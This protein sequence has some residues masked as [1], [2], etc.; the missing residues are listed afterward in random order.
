MSSYRLRFSDRLNCEKDL[1]NLTG[2][3]VQESLKLD[4]KHPSALQDHKEVAKDVSSFANS[5]G[6]V[7][8]YGIVEDKDHYPQR[9]EW[10]D[11]RNVKGDP[12]ETLENVITS[13]IHPKISNV[14]IKGVPSEKDRSKIVLIVDV[15]ESPLAPHMADFSYYK[16]WNFKAEPMEDYEVRAL[17]GRKVRPDLKVLLIFKE[18]DL[19]FDETGLSQPIELMASLANVGKALAQNICMFIDF[20]VNLAIEVENDFHNEVRWAEMA[21]PIKRLVCINNNAVIHP[22]A[23]MHWTLALLKVRFPQDNEGLIWTTVYAKDCPEKVGGIKYKIQ[24]NKLGIQELPEEEH[25]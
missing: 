7:V 10:I 24:D 13:L 18:S 12:K 19:Q 21:V 15:P 16:R 9:I 8:I 17:M 20:P 1:Q 14:I 2:G 22:T 25:Y 23:T 6:G 11:K 4:Y 5:E 3:M